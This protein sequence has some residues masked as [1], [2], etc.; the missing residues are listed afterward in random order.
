MKIQ[1]LSFPV[2]AVFVP[3]FAVF[4]VGC[5]AVFGA[6]AQYPKPTE[7]GIVPD[8]GHYSAAA[9]AGGNDISQLG[10]YGFDVVADDTNPG[11]LQVSF[12]DD[13]YRYDSIPITN[14]AFY[15]THGGG[16]DGTNFPTDE[17]HISGS[18]V[19]ASEAEG[20]FDDSSGGGDYIADL[21]Q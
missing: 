11:A 14:G 15:F 4:C 12:S 17:Y 7:T 21:V 5:D 18:F 2:L 16:A 1:R 6:P 19:T 13:H 10:K 20:Y 9:V 3:M 8:M